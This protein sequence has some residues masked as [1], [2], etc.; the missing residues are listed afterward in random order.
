[1]A[2][3]NNLKDPFV[4]VFVNTDN[5]VVIVCRYC[6]DEREDDEESVIQYK[7]YVED[8]AVISMDDIDDLIKELQKIRE[9]FNG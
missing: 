3:T 4:S 5:Q 6:I 2:I 9:K 8:S 7:E 1:M